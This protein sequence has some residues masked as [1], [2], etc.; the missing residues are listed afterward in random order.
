MN[1]PPALSESSIWSDI[2]LARLPFISDDQ[3]FW[4][5]WLRVFIGICFFVHGLGKLGLVGPKHQGG[6]L[7]AFA[8]W[9][10]SLGLPFPHLQARA[11]MASEL[12]GGLLIATGFGMRIGAVACL[13]TML[14]AMLLGHKGG[15]YLITNDP[16]GAEYTINLAAILIALIALG[17]G[18]YSVDF[19]FL[20]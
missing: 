5:L 15:G 13:G 18:T 10:K 8:G 19:Q 16:P 11:A 20:K 3:N 14:V 2:M 6:N 12:V 1:T 9:L 7:N 4:L 17:P